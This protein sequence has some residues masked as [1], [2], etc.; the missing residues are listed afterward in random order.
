[1]I[2]QLTKT[3]D[4]EY[5]YIDRDGI[6]HKSK[7][8]FLGDYLGF[9]GCGNPDAAMKLLRDVLRLL[10]EQKWYSEDIKALLPSEGLNYLV[11]YMLDDKGFTEHGTSVNCSWLTD[12][13]EELL[14]DLE[15]CL[16]N[17]KDEDEE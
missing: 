13:G 8:D 12:R 5:C 7:K 3:D 16:E 10:K 11:L 4:S 17:E 14:R 2:E 1:M 15:W 6:S 9:C